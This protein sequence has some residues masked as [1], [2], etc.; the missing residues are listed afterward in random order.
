MQRVSRLTKRNVQ[1]RRL[2]DIRRILLDP[3]QNLLRLKFKPAVE[4]DWL[5]T[6]QLTDL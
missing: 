2:S 5:S 6:P 1:F 3:S 4:N